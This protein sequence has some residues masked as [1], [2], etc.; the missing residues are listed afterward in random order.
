M[1]LKM[2]KMGKG[3]RIES[4]RLLESYILQ[5]RKKRIEVYTNDPTMKS[6]LESAY[7]NL[8][9]SILQISVNPNKLPPLKE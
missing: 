4:F 3:K 8:S 2:V 6:L 1:L 7:P 9:V 5:Q